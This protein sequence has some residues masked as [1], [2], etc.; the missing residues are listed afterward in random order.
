MKGLPNLGNKCYINSA[1]QLLFSSREFMISFEMWYIDKKEIGDDLLRQRF[2]LASPY[3][4]QCAR[5]TNAIS[6]YPIPSYI[7]S[8]EQ[9]LSIFIHIIGQRNELFKLESGQQS[10]AEFIIFLLKLLRVEAEMVNQLVNYL[11]TNPTKH[12]IRT[13]TRDD[14]HHWWYKTIDTVEYGGFDVKFST[15]IDDFFYNKIEISSKCDNCGSQEFKRNYSCLAFECYHRHIKH[16]RYYKIVKTSMLLGVYFRHDEADE[17]SMVPTVSNCSFCGHDRG[18]EILTLISAAKEMIII[19]DRIDANE[20][21]DRILLLSPVSVVPLP[22]KTKI[23]WQI[24]NEINTRNYYNTD[25]VNIEAETSRYFKSCVLHKGNDYRSGHYYNVSLRFNGDS[26]IPYTF[27]DESATLMTDLDFLQKSKSLNHY[28]GECVIALYN[29]EESYIFQTSTKK[30]KKRSRDD[31]YNRKKKLKVSNEKHFRHN[32]LMQKSHKLKEV[33]ERSH[34]KC[35]VMKQEDETKKK[36]KEDKFRFNFRTRHKDYEKN[37]E[38]YHFND[39]HRHPEAA[40][41]LYYFNSGLYAFHN[42]KDNIFKKEIQKKIK[43]EIREQFVSDDQKNKLIKK[44]DVELNGGVNNQPSLITCGCCGLRDFIRGTEKVH[45]RERGGVRYKITKVRE[46]DLLRYKEDEDVALREKLSRGPVMIFQ[47][48]DRTARTILPERAISYYYDE[49]KN[50]FYHLHREFVTID[51]DKNNEPDVTLC[52]DCYYSMFPLETSKTKKNKPKVP[53]MSIAAGVDF[54]DY[55]RIGLEKPNMCEICII[56]KVRTF[57]T[58]LKIQDNTG[59][60]RDY[61]QQTLRGHVVTFDHDAPVITSSVLDGFESIKKCFRLHLI[62]ED[63]KRDYLIEKVM[64][65]SIVLGRPYIILQWLVVLKRINPMYENMDIP[66]ISSIST[67]TKDTNDYVF[68]EMK[69]TILDENSLS[70]ELREEDDVAQV[71]TQIH[72]DKV[73]NRNNVDIEEK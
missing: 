16:K 3:F 1:M 11:S 65:S 21:E 61:T 62:C 39:W 42:L 34:K 69:V 72:K 2:L 48:S 36:D 13:M 23:H 24:Q 57:I 44:F 67:M 26:F 68:K 46:L 55:I 29:T 73:H 33:L 40:V 22:K 43:A 20:D 66:D 18:K 30:R 19:Y 31:H 12:N 59:Q 50:T 6:L 7:T 9:S 15:P 53:P 41:L 58:L 60:R 32:H 56:A 10:C 28:S 70:E 47:D 8:L 27:D 17:N 35:T 4:L 71:R 63:G 38:K 25:N 49:D 5:F 14:I 52:L 45:S 51:K 54:G 37:K 64:S